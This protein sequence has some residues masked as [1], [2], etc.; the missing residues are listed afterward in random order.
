LRRKYAKINK[1]LSKK[2]LMSENLKHQVETSLSTE[3]TKEDT[4][5]IITKS[6]QILDFLR[7]KS[8]ELYKKAVKEYNDIKNT[9]KAALLNDRKI[10]E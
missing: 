7:E 1:I 5:D 8:P 2:T 4:K 6:K 9:T 3:E 10:T